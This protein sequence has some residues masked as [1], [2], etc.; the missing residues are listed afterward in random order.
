MVETAVKSEVKELH[1]GRASRLNDFDN[2]S[3]FNAD[4][5]NVDNSNDFLRGIAQFAEIFIMLPRNLWHELCSYENL[6]LAYQKARKH[7]TT[8]DYVLE[9]EKNLKCNLITLQTE[10][11]LKSYRPKSL[12]SFIIRDP[13]TRKISKSDFRDRIV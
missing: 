2:D 1:V 6:F 12:V 9:F 3:R 8:K 7:K 10:L 11:F 13:K 4:D 5:R